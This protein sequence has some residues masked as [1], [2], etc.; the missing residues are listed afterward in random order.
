MKILN[1]GEKISLLHEEDIRFTQIVSVIN[2]IPIAYSTFTSI[3]LD[4]VRIYPLMSSHMSHVTYVI[5]S[6]FPTVVVSSPPIISYA[7]IKI[8]LM[9]LLMSFFLK[10]GR[11]YGGAFS[12]C[13]QGARW[14][15][16]VAD[17][18]TPN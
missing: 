4:P 16:G 15:Q 6:P 7:L 11:N 1:L 2:I 10:A 18:A 12:K 3:S 13:C 17:T 14:C 5:Y 9:V 8:K